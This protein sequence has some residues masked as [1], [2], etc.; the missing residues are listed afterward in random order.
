MLVL[1]R[2]VEVATQRRRLYESS[3]QAV[4]TI[5]DDRRCATI[6]FVPRLFALSEPCANIAPQSA[7]V[8]GVVGQTREIE[9]GL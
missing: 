6:S 9:R 4:F 2:P 8:G 3:Y 1:H 7:E 5:R